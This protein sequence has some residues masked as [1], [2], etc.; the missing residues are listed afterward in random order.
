M[1]MNNWNEI[2]RQFLLS[3]QIKVYYSNELEKVSAAHHFSNQEINH[4]LRTRYCKERF[5][6]Q[7]HKCIESKPSYIVCDEGDNQL[8][9]FAG[10]PNEVVAPSAICEVAVYGLSDIGFIP[11]EKGE[12]SYS[13]Y[14]A[15]G[16][17]LKHGEEKEQQLYED[18]KDDFLLLDLALNHLNEVD[19]EKIAVHLQ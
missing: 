2:F 9:A 8:V 10:S 19:M 14:L 12:G 7:V 16:E 13:E 18:D 6:T 4:F 5:W 11:D 17:R 15:Y 1:D 3:M